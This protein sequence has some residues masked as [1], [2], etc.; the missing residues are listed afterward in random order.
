MGKLSRKGKHTVKVG[1]HPHTNMVSKPAIVRRD[2][3]YRIMKMHLKLRNKQLKT[4]LHICRMLYQNLVGTTNQK[5]TI[6]THI[7]KKKKSNTNTTL[8]TVIKSQENKKGRE[9]KSPTSTNPNQLR[10]WQ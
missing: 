4:I 8:K 9:E 6:D 2:Y 5:S 10:K 1:N 7:L 3:K